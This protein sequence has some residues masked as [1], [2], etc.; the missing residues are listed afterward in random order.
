MHGTYILPRTSTGSIDK[1]EIYMYA[2]ID[3][4]ITT[5]YRSLHGIMEV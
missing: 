5:E 1:M 2:H 4:K 3:S